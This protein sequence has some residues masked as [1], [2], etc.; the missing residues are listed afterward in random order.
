MLLRRSIS[1]VPIVY[2]LACAPGPDVRLEPPWR[3][4]HAP[5]DRDVAIGSA[6]GVRVAA[7]QD[8]P[9]EVDAPRGTMVPIRVTLRNG[10][11]TP[12]AVTADRF[13]LV[14]PTGRRYLPMAP[15]QAAGRLTR[16]GDAD[17]LLMTA[18]PEGELR[19]GDRID[20]YLY[21]EPIVSR[22]PELGL[23]VQLAGPG[24]GAPIGPLTLAF[25]VER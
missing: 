5:G 19:A 3:Q 2:L 22:T 1:A 14:D 12:I 16:S 13:A 25:R 11:A 8:W 7:G 21:F 10:S 9:D 18:L 20:G 17:V 6:M 24:G 15:E 4:A 23:E